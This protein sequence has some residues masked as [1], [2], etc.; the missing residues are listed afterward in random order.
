M[1]ER[2]A[3]LFLATEG[4]NKTL[5]AE[6]V[7]WSDL[8]EREAVTLLRAG[9]YLLGGDM[10]HHFVKNNLP[11]PHSDKVWGASCRAL[12]AKGYMTKVGEQKSTSR[13]SH[14][15]S[16]GIYKSNLFKEAA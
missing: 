14:G 4:M 3:G 12:I 10:L 2:Q 8:Y 7:H 5:D 1:N 16:V 6:T 15:K 9:D 13:F 11:M